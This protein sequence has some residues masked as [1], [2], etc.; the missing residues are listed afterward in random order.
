MM[1]KQKHSNYFQALLYDMDG[2]LADTETLHMKSWHLYLQSIGVF[3]EKEDFYRF[4]GIGD[5]E[6]SRIII[7]EHDL[8]LTAGE[9]V[10]NRGKI[11]EKILSESPLSPLPG[12]KSL[13][14]EA[15]EKGIAQAVVTSSTR[16]RMNLILEKLFKSMS[17]NT[18]PECFFDVL[19][20][21][22]D[23]SRLKPDPELYMTAAKK[24][25]ITPECCVVFEDSHIGAQAAISAGATVV[26]VPTQYTKHMEF[27]PVHA[28]LISMDDIFNGGGIDTFLK[29]LENI[30][31]L[32]EQ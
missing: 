18:T 29:S 17:I 25:G 21:H 22:C 24:L 5:S 4:V 6:C 19:I 1:G 12:V 7:E 2:L 14:L 27:P 15:H 10:D 20:S 3:I 31:L 28:V 23:V 8:D 32:A 16:Q 30:R 13:L 9:M 11:F 26:T